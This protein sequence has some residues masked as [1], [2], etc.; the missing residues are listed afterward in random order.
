MDADAG[1]GGDGWGWGWGKC[2]FQGCFLLTA[3]GRR[4]RWKVGA[5]GGE[6]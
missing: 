1:V 3:M 6:V 4:L 2:S 5:E